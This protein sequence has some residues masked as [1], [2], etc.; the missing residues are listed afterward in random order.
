M[1]SAPLRILVE[2]IRSAIAGQQ[3]PYESNI[4]IRQPGFKPHKDAGSSRHNGTA[5]VHLFLASRR[6]CPE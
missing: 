2:Y 1:S 4:S 5:F 6:H 3:T